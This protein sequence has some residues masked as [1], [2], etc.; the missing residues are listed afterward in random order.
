MRGTIAAAVENEQRLLGVGQRNHQWMIA[1]Q[2]FIS[3]VINPLF[4]VGTGLD[5]GSISINADADFATGS[6]GWKISGVG[7]IAALTRSNEGIQLNGI[8]QGCAMMGSA[9]GAS[10]GRFIGSNAQGLILGV[11]AS[12]PQTGAAMTGTAVMQRQN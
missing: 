8:C 9:R 3:T 7:N 5:D 6:T 10:H 4:A 12:D 1:P 11:G 2:L